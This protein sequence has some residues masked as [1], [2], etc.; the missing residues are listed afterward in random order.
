MNNLPEFFI[1]EL[2][3]EYGVTIAKTIMYLLHPFKVN[4]STAKM[5]PPDCSALRAPTILPNIRIPWDPCPTSCSYRGV[6]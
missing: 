2:N 3:K 6:Q 1:E 4:D 5:I